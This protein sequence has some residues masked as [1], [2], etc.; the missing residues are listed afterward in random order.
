MY[1]T[2]ATLLFLLTA[3]TV[4]GAVEL[5]FELEKRH[6]AILVT[7]TVNGRPATLLVDTGAATTMISAELAGI[8][9]FTLE[10]SKF[11]EGQTGLQAVGVW[12]RATLQAG[13][14]RASMDVGAINLDEVT[15][16]YGRRIDGLLGQDVL[17]RFARITIDFEAKKLLL[18]QNVQ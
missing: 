3:T 6:G 16:R 14:W 1:R 18:A 7:L 11:R 8:D 13:S 5:P 17:R 15:A 12:E 10:R 4:H 2:T 9:R